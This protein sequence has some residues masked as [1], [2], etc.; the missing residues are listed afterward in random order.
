MK[1]Y[2]DFHI[3]TF[4]TSVLPRS[5]KSGIWK[6]FCLE[7][8][9]L[10]VYVQTFVKIFRM[11]EYGDFHI[12]T[13]FGFRVTLVNEQWHLATILTNACQYQPMC[14]KSIKIFL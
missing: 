9:T 12:C 8:V 7:R 6:F 10:N 11:D 2:G 3:F 4:M 13:F 1:T 5:M 14:E